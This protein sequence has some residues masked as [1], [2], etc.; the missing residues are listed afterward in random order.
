[1]KKVLDTQF[2]LHSGMNLIAHLNTLGESAQTG[3]NTEF[4]STGN[5]LVSGG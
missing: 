1:M 5:T 3:Q 4:Q 2:L